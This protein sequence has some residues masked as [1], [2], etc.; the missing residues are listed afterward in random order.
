LLNYFVETFEQVYGQH[1]VS[2][3]IHGLIHLVDDYKQYGPLDNC[4]TFPFEN[5]MKVL[6][7]MLRQ[8]NKPLEQVVMRYNENEIF[9]PNKN[10]TV[11]SGD[12]GILLGPHN[13]GHL[14]NGSIN[15][16]FNSLIFNSF[17][18]KSKVD[19]DSYFISKNNEI[20]KLINIAHS[21]N[22]GEVILIVKKFE[23]QE[24]FL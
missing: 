24:I 5:Y 8:P 20:I 11:Q 4:S 19:A 17:K 2:Y 14:L 13:D 22:T 7:S 12:N 9:S 15:S 23:I 18:F 16:Q 21:H 10:I 6:K 1:L 3:N